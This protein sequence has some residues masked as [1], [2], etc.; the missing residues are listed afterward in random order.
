MMKRRAS[1]VLFSFYSNLIYFSIPHL[2]HLMQFA[3]RME[4]FR[5]YAANYLRR[6]TSERARAQVAK[7]AW[8]MW[9]QFFAPKVL[10]D[11][12]YSIAWENGL[13]VR[14]Q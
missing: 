12:S 11:T 4:E 6:Q 1:F 3:L 2:M 8:R 10:L 14:N 7:L 9:I 5:E 13:C